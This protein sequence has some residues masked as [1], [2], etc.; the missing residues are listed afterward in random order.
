MVRR[1]RA[2]RAKAD[3]TTFPAE[4]EALRAKAKAIMAAH[5]LT[6]DDTAER[7]PE[8]APAFVQWAGTNGANYFHVPAGTTSTTRVYFDSQQTTFTIRVTWR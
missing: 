4:A 3:S 1:V 6:A 8:L 2:L 7:R 5:G